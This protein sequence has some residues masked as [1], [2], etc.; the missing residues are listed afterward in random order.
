VLRINSPFAAPLWRLGVDRDERLFVTSSAYKAATVWSLSELQAQ[1]IVRVPLRAEQRRRAHGVAIAPD[2]DVIAYG[3]PP[4]AE[5]NGV[6][7]PGT[8]RV[9]V[10][11]S[12]DGTIQKVIEGNIPSR[13]QALTY[14]ADGRY[15][16]AVLS[17]G[18][19]VRVWE[20]S[21][22]LLAGSDD[23]GYARPGTIG[24]CPGGQAASCAELPDTTGVVFAG[25]DAVPILVTSG[26]TGVRTYALADGRFLLQRRVQPATIGLERPEGIAVSPDG[27]AVA[28]ADRRERGS[29]R[30]D[31][32]IVLRVAVL[33]LDTLTPLR[34]PYE[35][36][37]NSSALDFPA[38]LDP[39]QVPAARLF[40]LHRVAW[41]RDGADE[42]IYAGG[43]LPCEVGKREL[44]QPPV[45]PQSR[46]EICLLRWSATKPNEAPRFIPVG[47]DRVMDI[48]PLRKSAQLIVATQRSVTIL[49]RDGRPS[50]RNDGT[51]QHVDNPAADFRGAAVRPFSI[52]PDAKRVYFE[53]YTSQANAPVRLLFDSEMLEIQSDVQS[54]DATIAPNRDLNILA[55]SAAPRDPRRSRWWV[56]SE[57]PPRFLGRPLV[58]N[59]LDKDDVYRSVA[60]HLGSRVAVVGSASFLRIVGFGAGAPRIR[61]EL[62]ISEEAYRVNITP[63]ATIVVVG[64]SDGALRWYR[65]T[66]TGDTCK[67]ELVLS[68]YLSRTSDGQWT[69]IAWVPTG[70]YANHPGALGLLSWQVTEA[71]GSVRTVDN[72]V[73]L[74]WYKHDVVKEAVAAARSRSGTEVAESRLPATL[75]RDI[76][77]A[78]GRQ[79]LDIA[80][81]LESTD[82]ASFRYRIDVRD[83]GKW[84]KALTVRTGEGHVISIQPNAAAGETSPP[85]PT[86]ALS[87]RSSGRAEFN[88]F[89]PASALFANGAVDLCF[90][91]DGR[92]QACKAI[93]YSG[94]LTPMPPRKLYAVVA[95]FS[96]YAS[97]E[98]TLRFAQNDAID[99]ARLLVEERARGTAG[100]SDFAA[101]EIDLL[102]GTSTP[103]AEAEAAK[104]AQIDGV[105]RRT[106]T[107]EGLVDALKSLAAR[108]AAGELGNAVFV[109]YFSG[110]GFAHPFNVKQ[111]LTALATSTATAE[112]SPDN[113]ARTTL[114]SD[115]LIALVEG[116]AAQRL[117]I[118]DA[119]RAPPS[120]VRHQPFKAGALTQEFNAQALRTYF[121]FSA[122]DGQ[123]SLEQPDFAYDTTRADGQ[124]GNGLFTYGLLDAMK[125]ASPHQSGQ[126]DT[127]DVMRHLEAQVFSLNNPQS[128]V[129]RLEQSRSRRV[130]QTP[131]Y[132]VARQLGPRHIVLRTVR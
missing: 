28:V 32:A 72:G 27:K 102:V 21:S 129:R 37:A 48:L 43:Y 83:D 109:F 24:C 85:A 77:E 69:W 94:P 120:I 63:D 126:V 6:P 118:I 128:I 79:L 92:Q 110:H 2:G 18:C 71:N 123:Y 73:L 16:A 64:H 47:T 116:I 4:L 45:P 5:A 104:L 99:M 89:L 100:G 105:R 20:T 44:V 8:A 15:L 127:E 38:F 124:R 76:A 121:F 40:S 67:L 50:Q 119:C 65:H 52:S 74:N 36:S 91:L 10:A 41:A 66:P 103:E 84:P 111:G 95:G 132:A 17:S 11:R 9:Y 62:P 107:R 23:E 115:E 101:V 81:L 55:D 70:E 131:H 93:H 57:G 14:S 26:D 46:G 113:F 33:A 7:Q 3:V 19:G 31:R 53:D 130:L 42:F 112:I 13:P 60:L 12:S 68:A 1:T 22:W 61:C 122:L 90:F 98:L 39:A 125:N 49:D 35:I 97:P 25:T 87:L 114:A 86:P 78:A 56:D 108:S 75:Q 80:S 58:D 88:L 82:K 106:A 30:S 29:D 51:A 34:E 54:G 59:R 96:K 117:V